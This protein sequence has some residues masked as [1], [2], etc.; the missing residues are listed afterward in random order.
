LRGGPRARFHCFAR[1]LSFAF[2]L[3]GEKVAAPLA[4]RRM[5]GE[6]EG[7]AAMK[8]TDHGAP[9]SEAATEIA[10]KL[11]SQATNSEAFLWR[12]LRSKGIAGAKF[13]RQHPIGRYVADFFC[14][15]LGLIVEVDGTTHESRSAE[16]GKRQQE[17]E[18][19]GLT[20]LRFGDAEVLNE[21]DHVLK[22]ITDAAEEMRKRQD[23]F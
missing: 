8:N 11:R 2:L 5:R 9:K 6:R 18:A 7:V 22:R 12:F 20:V 13:R 15:E 1:M 23:K 10:R 17:L 21:T 19:L 3:P 4:A 16:D 14:F